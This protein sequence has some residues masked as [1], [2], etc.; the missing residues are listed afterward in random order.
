ML[1]REPA[2]GR[3]LFVVLAAWA[4]AAT[5][6]CR[7]PQATVRTVAIGNGPL[8]MPL[9]E[10]RVRGTPVPLLLDSG[11]E[12]HFLTDATAWGCGVEAVGAEGEGRDVLGRPVFAR[13][14]EAGVLHV[15]GL[16]VDRLDAPAVVY[17]AALRT[18]GYWGGVSPQRLAES[19]ERVVLDFRAG[20]LTVVPEG[21]DRSSPAGPGAASGPLERC[22]LGEAG[23]DRGWYYLVDAVVDGRETRLL[24]D[25]GSS[26]TV[27][28]DDVAPGRELAAR[29]RREGLP[30]HIEREP[31]EAPPTAEAART[32]I[33]RHVWVGGTGEA[34]EVQGTSV[35]LDDWERTTAV[36]VV[37]RAERQACSG[38]GVLGF[39]LLRFCELSLGPEGGDWRCS[40]AAPAAHEPPRALE[41]EPVRLT[42]VGATAACGRTAEELRPD[43][44]GAELPVTYPSLL[45]AFAVLYEGVD[46]HARRI[47]A[48]CADRGWATA[49]VR[50]PPLVRSED[51]LRVWFEVDEGPRYRVG[52]VT[53]RV[54]D[55]DGEE[56]RR[57]EPEELPP[58]RQ[59]S[60]EWYSAAAWTDD[61]FDL[62]DALQ[63]I[64]GPFGSYRTEVVPDEAAGTLELTLDVVLD[65]PEPRPDPSPP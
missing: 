19:G 13:R 20:R 5:A 14:A 50:E 38:D 35:A 59:R 34:L 7:P 4:L 42:E 1:E 62:W 6:G 23:E 51:E 39:D 46:E 24:V 27:L 56:R 18:F 45:E 12:W 43:V 64:V 44:H 3:R 8:A 2:R 65:E 29:A 49:R 33:V 54:V 60:G 57:V 22:R 25:T 31:G 48:D 40:D 63:S 52:A 47:E 61:R 53:I 17:S 30:A 37:T 28:Y 41:G 58:L 11:A 21:E 9:L 10:A 55:A 36:S 15:P 16:P 26:Q 32:G